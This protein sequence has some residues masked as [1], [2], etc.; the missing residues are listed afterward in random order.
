MATKR[1][2][3]SDLDSSER[4]RSPRYVT[5]V[6]VQASLG[7]TTV[8]I[9]D[10]GEAGFQIEH[11]QPLAVGSTDIIRF[12][13]GRVFDWMHRS[14]R[15]DEKSPEAGSFEFE[16]RTV[17]SR[18]SP[19]VG[20][21]ERYR[22]GLRVV[23]ADEATLSALRGLLGEV[24]RSPEREVSPAARQAMKAAR[25]K[26]ERAQ[27]DAELRMLVELAEKKLR[28]DPSRA[29]N[30]YERSA[31]LL[32]RT[33]LRRR[34]HDHYSAEVLA[35]WHYLDRRISLARVARLVAQRAGE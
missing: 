28:N 27:R 7:S 29:R 3:V 18:V 22:S 33:T 32:L 20:G 4:R 11:A 24:R 13:H 14:I 1:S 31:A 10:L 2:L 15:L 19:G 26:A 35:I 17:W 30:H 21:R 12:V 25:A 6:P 9:Y 8:W 16:S 34:L 5:P 23:G